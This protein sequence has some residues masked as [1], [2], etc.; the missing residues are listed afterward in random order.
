MTW[1]HQ[2]GFHTYAIRTAGLN[3]D[4]H[5]LKKVIRDTQQANI[6]TSMCIVLRCHSYWEG[7]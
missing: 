5:C 7:R 6:E 3:V 2:P 1:R 4:G